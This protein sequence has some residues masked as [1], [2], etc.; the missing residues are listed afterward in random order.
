MA[1]PTPPL[2]Q[3]DQLRRM[4]AEPTQDT[5]TDDLLGSYLAA[6]PLP[7]SAGA[8]PTD[9]AWLGAWDA[10]LAAAQVWEE[11]AAAVAGDYD[12]TADGGSYQRSQVYAQMMATARGFRS[13]RKTSALVLTAQPPPDAVDRDA[14][15]GNAAED[16]D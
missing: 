5:Y 7:D 3:I 1:T 4:V 10:A 12:F 14:W 2:T 13:R 16:D 11:K 9:T 15:L 6:Y 8:I